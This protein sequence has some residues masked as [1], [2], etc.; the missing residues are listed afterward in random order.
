MKEGKIKPWQSRG[1]MNKSYPEEFF[2]KVLTNNNISFESEKYES[3]YFLDFFIQT[4]KGKIDLE[5][6]GKQ[7]KER[8][9]H[10][11]ERDIKLSNLGYLVYRIKWNEI[12]SDKGSS[13]M[14]DKINSFLNFYHSFL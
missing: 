14:K 12:N 11:Q 13:K 5:I 9:E 10:D 1:K 6:D 3:G 7:H 4:P 2:I 8:A